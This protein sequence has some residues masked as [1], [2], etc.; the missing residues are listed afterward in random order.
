MLPPARRPQAYLKVADEEGGAANRFD[1]PFADLQTRLD[2]LL[3]KLVDV[4]YVKHSSIRWPEGAG[5][6]W[7]AAGQASFEY[8]MDDPV[9]LP[10][11]QRLFAEEGFAQHFSSR[12]IEAFFANYMI[13]AREDEAFDPREHPGPG[14][15]M[16]K[17]KPLRCA[18]V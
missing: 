15:L 18:Y 13:D 8:V 3:A 4:G 11:A 1:V 14:D 2:A 16:G 17:P 7:A 9:I 5:E 6:E 10:S 12:T